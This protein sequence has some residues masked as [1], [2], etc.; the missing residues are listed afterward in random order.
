MKHTEK[1]NELLN[2][3]KYNS[4][5]LGILEKCL[6]D[7]YSISGLEGK[8]YSAGQLE[9]FYYAFKDGV[10]MTSG[11]NNLYGPGQLQ[12]IREGLKA[13][14]T[15]KQVSL[16]AVRDAKTLKPVYSAQ[17][18]QILKQ[19]LLDGIDISG[20][21]AHSLSPLE[22]DKKRRELIPVSRIQKLED[23]GLYNDAQLGY[24]SDLVKRG[25]DTA[26]IENAKLNPE[27]MQELFLAKEEN[28]LNAEAMLV[29][30]DDSFAADQLR[31]L[32][33][34]YAAGINA[35]VYA[36]NGFH[37]S[38]M[39]E[40]RLAKEAGL[41][42]DSFGDFG[43]NSM[44]MYVLR[45]AKQAGIKEEIYN[46][47]NNTAFSASQMEVMIYAAR[48][49]D[50]ITR[51]VNES[52]SP[53]RM[54]F[55]AKAMHAG[56][57]GSD[58]RAL[59]NPD[60]SYMEAQK[61]LEAI[62]RR[63]ENIDL[64][65][66]FRFGTLLRNFVKRI[67]ENHK[68][69]MR[70]A[71]FAVTNKNLP[72]TAKKAA[73]NHD[74]SHRQLD[75]LEEAIHRNIDIKDFSNPDMSPEKMRLL[76]E[77]KFKGIDT[78]LLADADFSP[79]QI[80]ICLKG[81]EDAEKLGYDISPAIHKHLN[82]SQ[83]TELFRAAKDGVNIS[84]IVD[85]GLTAEAIYSVKLQK[86]QEQMHAEKNKEQGNSE[87]VHDTP[88]KEMKPDKEKETKV[89]TVDNETRRKP[90]AEQIAF[91]EQKRD[92]MVKEKS[93]SQTKDTQKTEKEEELLA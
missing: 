80:V 88:E 30:M 33:L 43:H 48:R 22:M 47:I 57:N 9:Q 61:R 55:V 70:S 42:I 13:G 54:R 89:F 72:E 60:L 27:Q 86:M 46:K 31:E 87:K 63:K 64:F 2:S 25:Y 11:V 15:D 58:L 21:L 74:Y 52:L 23:S 34:G 66:D 90:L 45:Q 92:Q 53:E 71:E 6:A 44:Q 76:M 49:G 28:L 12:Q 38:Q 77:G 24:L 79:E 62:M 39:R 3:G 83:M 18:M 20:I 41:D 16:Y 19:G 17:Q 26:Y 65:M 35:G 36:H 56:V 5:Q 4:E 67:V 69:G 51:Y 82:V 85:A 10:D 75:V 7:G 84:E 78:S 73:E 14:L 1:L 29:L 40:M 91:F 8:N 59:A 68:H 93:V 32:R 37:S 50:D 81:L